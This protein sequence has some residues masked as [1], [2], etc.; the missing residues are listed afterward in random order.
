MHDP[1]NTVGRISMGGRP[2]GRETAALINRH[3]DQ[4]RTGAQAGDL[5]TAEQARCGSSRNQHGTDDQVGVIESASIDSDRVLR[6]VARFSKSE[7]GQEIQ[8]D[9][10]DGIRTLVSVGYMVDEMVELL[11]RAAD[12]DY[13]APEMQA[14]RPLIEVQRRWSQLPTPQTL[15]AHSA[16]FGWPSS[17]PSR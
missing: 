5:L 15:L 13:S 7:C 11:A 9:V 1:V 4:H 3:I 16:L 8:Q 10:L 14:A 2:A 12:G 17:L 6:G